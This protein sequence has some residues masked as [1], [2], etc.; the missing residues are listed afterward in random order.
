MEWLDKALGWLLG[1]TLFVALVTGIAPNAST[2]VVALGE[3]IWPGYGA[4]LRLDPEA[5]DCDPV[6]VRERAESC[7]DSAAPEPAGG[8][9]FAD[10]PFAE[11]APKPAPQPEVDPFAEPAADP[12]AEPAGGAVEPARAAGVNCE[13]V[14]ALADRCETRWADHE[15]AEARRTPAVQAY[16]QLDRAVD[17]LARFPWSRQLLVLLVLCGALVS[18]LRRTHIALRQPGSPGEHRLAEGA[19]LLVHLAWLGSCLADA[20]IQ[21][22]SGTELAN[23]SL[24]WIWAAGFGALAA[25]H[26]R[27][28]L[29]PPAGLEG[30]GLNPLVVP[31]YA[32]MAALAVGWFALE[33]H[34]SGQAI[35]LHKFVQIPSI[36]LGIGLYIWAG[37]LLARTSLARRVF[38]VLLPW[39]L[40]PALLGWLV[41]VLAALPT[42]YSGASGIFVIAAGAVIFERL[43]EA[44][45]TK[46]QALAATAMSG[47][48]GVVLRPCLVVVLVAVLNPSV[49][50]DAL[51]AWGRWVF[52]LTAG[53]TL[54]AMLLWN[55]RPFERPDVGQALRGTL[56]ALRGLMPFAVLGG[57]GLVAYQVLLGTP[58][59]EHTAAFVLPGLLL[60]VA[61]WDLRGPDRTSF[62]S[63]VDQA[64]HHG[65]EHIGALLLVM[66]GSVGVGGVVERSEVLEAL[67]T[68]FGSPWLAMGFLVVVMV[69]VGMTMDALGAVILVS[70]SLAHVAEANGIDPV[71]FWM[72][73]LVA[74]EL[75]YLTPPVALNHLL[76]R[77]VIGSDADLE[78]VEGGWARQHAHV[79]V[80]MAVM[81][82][83]L[84][85]VAFGPLLVQS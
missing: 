42:A 67:P 19:Q 49:T 64:G 16:R 77:Q 8:D 35:H 10:D 50:T 23:A 71:H 32:W 81:G 6:V 13:A 36:Y 74:F 85:V 60:L 79:L 57:L 56:E 1:L 39:K 21:Q 59:T 43:L 68:D 83:A 34:P 48:L 20:W 7:V 47:S 80:P 76:A 26:G 82:V 18:S 61:A 46:R 75:G 37:M 9:P 11:P 38:D 72:M 2:R 22:T 5:P 27:S 30:Q 55:D 53:L 14:R 52:A 51:F 70:V 15:A 66:A 3:R 78:P 25:V 69:L 4:E 33:Q 73:V 65:A 84:V 12:F 45:A 41:V 24:P 31:L 40:P 54:V 17:R 44:G 58:L 62:W 28:L 63:A 29:R